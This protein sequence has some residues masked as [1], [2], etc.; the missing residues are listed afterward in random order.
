[1]SRAVILANG[2]PP[3]PGL[4]KRALAQSPLFLCADGGANTARQLGVKP[5]AIVGD[6]D[7]ATP[8]TLAHFRDVP[9]IQDRSAEHT[10]L[11]KTIA[12]ALA[13]G[14]LEEI[15]LLGATGRLDHVIE[16]LGLMRKY[17][18]RVR[19][20]MEDD[21]GRAYVTSKDVRLTCPRG[22]TVSF[23]AV[24][25]PVE[26]LTTENLK[27][28]LYNVTLELGVQD[29]ISNVV[30]ATPAW[31]RFRQGDLLVIEATP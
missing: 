5:A 22:T 29:S 28:P 9:Q 30:E 1:M 10:D 4:I 8:E 2:T 11:D 18:N 12:Y 21:H 3:P 14:P 16:H 27:Y 23:F 17:R 13:Q 7:S 15:L 6:F 25:R 31:I 26:G 24:G 20:V 19:L